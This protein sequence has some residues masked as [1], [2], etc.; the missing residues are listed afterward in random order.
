[1]D[2]SD[3]VVL[4]RLLAFFSLFQNSGVVS[5][6]YRLPVDAKNTIAKVG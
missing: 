4:P 3:S 1:M 2:H 5:F 6:V